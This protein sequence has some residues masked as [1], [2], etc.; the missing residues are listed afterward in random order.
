MY[1]QSKE[2]IS[3]LF[4]P[5]RGRYILFNILVRDLIMSSLSV[6]YLFQVEA[7]D[8]DHGY[9]GDL[10]FVISNGDQDSVFQIN[11]TTGV[12]SIMSGL[13]REKTQDYMLNITACDQGANQKCTSIL[14]HV[15]VLDQ[16][17]NSPVFMKSAFSFFFPE[18]TRNGT[19][20]VTL[21]ATD[22]DSGIY[23]EVTYI[24][25][26]QT[27]DFSLNP[28]TGVLIVSKELDRESREFYDLT[29]RA[30][31]GDVDKPLSAYATVR[32][33][34]LDVNDVA[35]IFTSKEYFVKAREDLPVGSV[36]GFV[37]ASDP[38][39]YQGGQIS[40]SL[41]GEERE[42]RAG[43]ADSFYIDQRTG[44]VKIR[45]ELD[46]ESKQLYNLTVLAVDGGSPSLVSLA[47]FIIEILDVNENIHPPIFDSF[48]SEAAVPENMPVG[49]LVTKVTAKD[50]DKA[51][52]DDSRISFSI[53]A[54][55][56]LNSFSIDD[57]GSVRSAVVLDR[58]SKKYYWLTVYAQDHGASPL[59]SKMEIFIEVLNVND[60]VP[61]TLFP[62]YFPSIMEN[63]KPSTPIVTLEAFDGDSDMHQQLVYEIISGDPQSLF[64]INPTT[65]QI[66][67]TQ[68]KLDRET[69]GEH[70]L[71]V[72]VS[73]T[74]Q[75][76]LN[77]TSQVIVTVTDQN[78][79]APTFLERYYKIKIPEIRIDRDESIQKDQE[80]LSGLDGLSSEGYDAKLDAMFE[81]AEWEVFDSLNMG[82]KSV[83]RVIAF[84]KDQG[85][86]A[87]LSYSINNGLT[88]GKFRIN[89]DTGMVHTTTSLLAGEKYDML[90]KA[91]DGGE[92]PLSGVARVSIEVAPKNSSPSRHPPTIEPLQPVEVFETDPVGQLV[93]LVVGD[94]GD[95]ESLF[96]DIVEGNSNS[97]FSV[98]RDK[99]SLIIARG[100]DWDRQRQ[101][102]LTISLTDGT[103]TTTTILTVNV[104][105]V[106]ETRPEFSS[107]EF[108][109]E[110]PENSS[111]GSQII[112]LNVTNSTRARKL[113]YS[114]HTAQ[115]PSSLQTFK[116]NP[117]DGAISLRQK[118]DRESTARHII[119][120]SVKDTGSPSKKNF[121]R[122][123]IDVVDHND[124]APQFLSQL[125]QTKLYETAVVGSS[126]VQAFAVDLDHGDNGR[127]VYSILS[128]NIGNSFS[129]DSQLGLVRVARQLDMTVQAEYML[130]LKATDS[131]QMPLSATVP[132][133][134]MLT[135][136]DSAPP[137]FLSSHYATELYEDM[138]LGH[139]V[140]QL[141]ARSQSSLYYEITAGNQEGKFQI[142]PSTGVIM[143]RQLLDFEKTTFYNLT[144]TV[145]NMVAAKSQTNL[146]IHILDVNDNP[147]MFEKNFFVGNISETA[148]PGSLVLVNNTAPLV[149]RATDQ[150]SG[151]NSLLLYEI[152]EEHAKRYFSIDSSTGAIRTLL[153][154]DYETQ[155]E[156]EFSVRVSDKGKPRLSAQ[157]M[158]RVNIFLTDENDSPPQFQRKEYSQLVLLPTFSNVSVLQVTARDPDSEAR[159][160]LQFSIT[161]GNKLGL[162]DIH[163]Q[164][165]RVFIKLPRQIQPNTKHS[166]QLTVSDGKFTDVC[167]LNIAVRKSDNSGLAFSKSKYYTTV[168]ENTTKADVI[169][170][171]NVLGSALNEILEFRL[172][173]P[174][175][176]FSIGRTS[177]ALR[178]T[179]KVFDREEK[180]NY[181]L[182]VEVR[183]QERQRSIPR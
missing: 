158:A 54:G 109:V 27:E 46:Y 182:I 113:F 39:L 145:S 17:D 116:I 171:V 170:V 5:V 4:L 179:G 81:H 2:F 53:R 165:G 136:A 140:I 23:G 47:S 52:S 129:I 162:F 34:I 73:D 95:G 161:A 151:L 149:I 58:E 45:K 100:L 76:S 43:G 128:G 168:L 77:S 96:Y 99:G 121:A 88:S 48:Y 110:M 134:I 167:N 169:L 133:H 174:S 104:I 41:D 22:L 114:L 7:E 94:D 117:L 63:S 3:S 105:K 123:I 67:T 72:R 78:D 157:S 83:F 124:H 154:L 156:F 146:D 125:I 172:L 74:G 108:S 142:N 57:T 84:D 180:E 181:E 175:D 18:N 71:E 35:P 93:T 25:E 92:S 44:A 132:V 137:R 33:R 163:P 166:L 143:T 24:L 141:E 153:A 51:G 66:L 80:N 56:G 79:N 152:L 82:G 60:N 64:S 59:Y 15:I 90:V 173:N 10:V 130:I 19:P 103:D 31:D 50:F 97:D 176:M 55:D 118:L 177:G 1:L 68:R 131:G 85:S 16:N 70:I 98:S 61:L 91:T 49:S 164:T 106:T 20:V 75:P 155:S 29:V 87:E 30:V 178:T 138:A 135:M 32:V 107:S 183:S 139:S 65:G 112:V 115:N 148:V 28:K 89:P 119:T 13:D 69:Q 111:L 36:V 127:I 26:T 159:S 160:A 11:M 6:L 120:V 40:F 38:D 86:N 122:L 102:N 12:V 150:D 8:Q 42:R 144:V 9:N 101:Y 147:P 126:V 37:D 14:S 62:A 21:N